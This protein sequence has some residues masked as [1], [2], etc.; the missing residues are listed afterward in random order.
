MEKQSDRDALSKIRR[1]VVEAEWHVAK[2]RRIVEK[3]VRDEHPRQA[4]M[5]RRVLQTLEHSLA[6]A[7]DHLSRKEQSAAFE[8]PP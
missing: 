3:M 1:H 4:E 8:G 2:L 6:L 5:A 7:R